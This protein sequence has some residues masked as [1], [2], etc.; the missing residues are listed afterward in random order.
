MQSARRPPVESAGR[1]PAGPTRP[2]TTRSGWATASWPS[3]GSTP[4][5]TLAYLAGITTRVRLGTAVLLPALR[6]PVV[7]AQQIANVDQISRAGWC[8]GW[9]WAGACPS[10]SASGRRAA[11]TTSARVRRLEEHIAIWRKLWT[12]RAGDPSR[13]R[14]RPG[15]PHH[16]AAAVAD[17]GAARADHRGQSRRAAA[18]AVRALRPARRRHHHDLRARRGVPV[19][20]ERARG[21]AG[22]ARPRRAR[23]FPSASTRRC[24]WT[25]TWRTAERVTTEFL[26][27]Y[28]G[29]GVH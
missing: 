20:R 26:A 12:R 1:W 8:W 4:L 6:H 9:A 16:R 27:T 23:T 19:V 10:P 29:G 13:G 28:Y 3:R 22:A 2:A 25:T 17:R 21:G 15:R 7:L 5:T 14:P 18:R 11:P 24:G